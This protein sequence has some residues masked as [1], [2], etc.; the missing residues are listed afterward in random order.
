M[1]TPVS[2]SYRRQT[3][4]A[5]NSRVRQTPWNLLSVKPPISGDECSSRRI[6]ARAARRLRR[7]RIPGP[8]LQGIGGRRGR[9]RERHG[10]AQAL[11]RRFY[12]AQSPIKRGFLGLGW[13][14]PY[15]VPTFGGR[16]G[17]RCGAT[18]VQEVAWE[19]AFS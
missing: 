16:A 18:C 7:A 9:Q 12:A 2:S 17:G 4:P 1:F 10:A 13:F 19:R 14:R 3:Q 11:T 8:Q 6:A 5:L 15:S